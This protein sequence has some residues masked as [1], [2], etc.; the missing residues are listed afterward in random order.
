MV[1]CMHECFRLVNIGANGSSCWVTWCSRVALLDH[2]TCELCGDYDLFSYI[3][4]H[5]ISLISLCD[6]NYVN[7]WNLCEIARYV[8]CMS[9]YS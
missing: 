6:A 4:M 3:T 8:E 2:C 9:W 7:I 1:L 5:D